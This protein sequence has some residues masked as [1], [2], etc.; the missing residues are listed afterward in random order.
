LT[1]A[2]GREF[3]VDVGEYINSNVK[4]EKKKQSQFLLQLITTTN[5]TFGLITNAY[6]YK[7]NVDSITFAN[8]WIFHHLL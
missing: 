8:L 3:K 5:K 7:I 4:K 2:F 6:T 1:K